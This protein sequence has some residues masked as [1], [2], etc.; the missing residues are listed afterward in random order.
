MTKGRLGFGSKGV[1]VKRPLSA[2]MVACFIVLD[3]GCGKHTR[4]PTTAPPI[5][6][7]L[8]AAPGFKV[9]S[10]APVVSIDWARQFGTTSNDRALGLSV[11]SS[12]N[13]YVT[14]FTDGTLPGQSSAGGYDVYLRK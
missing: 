9:Q 11:D 6:A 7:S 5:K 2:L 4:G 3:V 13:A 14:G 8:A 1:T 10:V 12:G